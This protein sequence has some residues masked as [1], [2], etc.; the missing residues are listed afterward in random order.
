MWKLKK[1]Y[2]ERISNI[3][4]FDGTIAVVKDTDNYK[5]LKSDDYNFFFNKKDGYFIRWGSK[6]LN[7]SIVSDKIT[8]QEM[9]LFILWS[10]IW[11][12]KFDLKEF[13]ADL[14]TDGSEINTAPEL[15]DFEVSTKCSGPSIGGNRAHPC[16][17]CY[18][19]NNSNGSY[20]S[21]ENFTKIIDTL[22]KSV[23]QCA[24]GIGN[25]DQPNLF[26]L[27]DICIDRD[28]KPNITI[29]GDRMTPDIYD[30]LA[31]RCG[32][33]SISYYDKDLTFN[34]VHELATLR[35]M[36]QINIHYFLAEETF[37][38]G[39]QLIDDIKSDPRMINFNALVFLSAKLR[40]NA[41][42]ND[43]HILS[44]EKYNII[45]QKA[46]DSGIS[47]GMDSCSACKTLIAY[48]DNNNFKSI[49]QSVEKCESS[50][51]SVYINKSGYYFPCSFSEGIES[52][53]G[54]W[55]NGISVLNCNSFMDDIWFNK[56]TRI[57][58]DE[59]VRCR[60]CNKSCA[61]FDI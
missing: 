45:A 25:V 19:S 32:A 18:K 24:M 27:M 55:R 49:E 50:I 2:M 6:K 13:V 60:K 52:A 37:D 53:P 5:A 31:K 28:I 4:L 1:L 46:L 9:E 38:Q 14:K 21:T 40:G 57:F 34:A 8:K 43:Y 42:K 48:K 3:T 33:I 39:M 35:E 16:S 17:F 61:I 22:P 10:N 36:K 30:N 11:K 26:E 47:V 44:Q 58:S 59:V 12:E 23:M 29:N 7:E 51:Y 20:I 41:E 15:I 54:D 56:K